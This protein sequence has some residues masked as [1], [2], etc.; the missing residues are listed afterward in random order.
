[1]VSCLCYSPHEL[2]ALGK[3][4]RLSE[5][6]S[7]GRRVVSPMGVREAVSRAPDML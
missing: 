3:S 4:L 7:G 6:L 2:C 1:M 5:P